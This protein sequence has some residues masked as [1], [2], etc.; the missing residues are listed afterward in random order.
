M[1]KFRTAYSN[2]I[3]EFEVVKETEKQIVFL[4]KRGREEREAKQTHYNSWFDTREAAKEHLI[5][6]C[7][8][9]ISHYEKMVAV[10]YDQ[11]KEI[12]EL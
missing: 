11:L 5:S 3:G 4:N 6:K 2:E 12:K 8:E 7:L 1:K 9:K 10:S